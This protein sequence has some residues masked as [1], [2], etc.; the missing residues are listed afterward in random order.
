[1][2]IVAVNIRSPRDD[3]ARVCELF[4]LGAEFDAEDRFQAFFAGVGTDG[5]LQLRSAQ[6]VEETA[7]HGRAVERT[8]RASV[9]VGQ[10]GFGA[11]LGDGGSEA[12]C[13][14]V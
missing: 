6:A 5:T 8:E 1:V 12:I 10:D 2:N 4:G 7:I 13:D 14:F 9:G 11:V 3:V